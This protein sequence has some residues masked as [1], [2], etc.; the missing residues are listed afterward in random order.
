MQYEDGRTFYAN[1]VY[2]TIPDTDVHRIE[3]PVRCEMESNKSL[4]LTINP[5][6]N[7]VICKGYY[8]VSMKLYQSDS[9]TELV[10]LYPYEV[11]LHSNLHVELEIES[12]DEELQVFIETLIA[13]PSLE[14]TNKTYTVIQDGCHQDS[15]LQDHQV[16]DHR[17]QRFSFHA[18]VF[19]NFPV[20]YLTANVI[21]CHNSV[22]PNRC[23]QGCIPPRLRRDVNTTKK[24]L[25][26]ARL[27]QGPIVFRFKRY[28]YILAPVLY[29]ALGIT[30]LLAG[31]GMVIQNQYYR[32]KMAALLQGV[33]D[34]S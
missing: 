15:T 31:L 6:V 7:N 11:D 2:G 19:D 25:D 14:D 29:I 9:F 10:T 1:T 12:E 5:K 24:E 28:N 33:N 23:T 22:S 17:L 3:I 30:V 20:V 27:S 32:R 18:L 21:I 4:E 34:R 16:T 13:S 8:N 26:T